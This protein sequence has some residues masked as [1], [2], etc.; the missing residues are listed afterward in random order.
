MNRR[1]DRPKDYYSI[2]GVSPTAELVVIR[3]AY[4]AL[5]LRYHPDTWGGD[6]TQAENLMRELN[7]AYEVLSNATSRKIY[8]EQ[9][10]KPGFKDSRDRGHAEA[11]FGR[12][13]DPS[14]GLNPTGRKIR[15]WSRGFFRAWIVISA[16]WV[17]ATVSCHRAIY[18]RSPMERSEV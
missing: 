8:D 3:A 16:V 11:G 6:K 5:A 2:L 10:E 14:F 4:R 18:I 12:R 17:V 9:R 13:E 7:E 15:C 1:S